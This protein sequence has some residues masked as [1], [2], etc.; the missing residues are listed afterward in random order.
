[1][2]KELK[3]I[4]KIIWIINKE[5]LQKGNQIDIMELKTT[6]ADMKKITRRSQQWI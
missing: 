6:I 2:D 3:E 5:K 4:R 1:M